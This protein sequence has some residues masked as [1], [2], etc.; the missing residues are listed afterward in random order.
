MPLMLSTGVAGFIRSLSA[1]LAALLVCGG[2]H[3]Q[4]GGA[5]VD[6]K[7]LQWGLGGAARPGGWI[8]VQVQVTDLGQTTREVLLE[9]SIPDPDGDTTLFQ[10]T[11]AV[12]GEKKPTWIYARLPFAAATMNEFV[13]TAHAVVEPSGAQ[14]DAGVARGGELLGRSKFNIPS[15]IEARTG[16]FGVIGRPQVGLGTFKTDAG[17]NSGFAP[18]AHEKVDIVSGLTVSSL[19]DR[20]M[21]LSEMEA[22]VWTGTG[23]DLEP[24]DLPEDRA[25]AIREWVMRGG[26]LIIV[27]PAVGQTWTNPS[28]PLYDIFPRV[29][30]Q[31]LEN[32]DMKP[33]RPLLTDK[34]IDL[35]PDVVQV[36][37]PA[38]DAKPGEATRI[39]TGPDGKAVV[40]SR[41]VGFGAV[42][43]VGLN[44]TGRPLDNA[45]AVKADVFWNRVM[46]RRGRLLTDTEVS[47]AR[48]PNYSGPRNFTNR[49]QRAL[50]QDIP[51]L[52]NKTGQAF[53]GVMLA[54]VL[55]AAY[56]VVAGPLGFWV[57]KRR[58]RTRHAWVGFV[59]VGLCFTALAWG[60][61]TVLKPGKLDAQHL[62][63]VDHVYGQNQ[64]RAKVWMS[65]LLPRFGLM[66]VGIGE[67][68]AA[69]DAKNPIHNTLAP[70]DPAPS[71]LAV[72]ATS[73]FADSQGYGVASRAPAKVLTPARSTTKNYVGEWMGG[74]TWKM[75]MPFTE[76]GSAPG[77]LALAPSNNPRG[78]SIDGTLKHELPGTLKD[79]YVIV[80]RGQKAVRSTEKYIGQLQ[81]EGMWYSRPEWKAGELL[82]VDNEGQTWNHLSAPGRQTDSLLLSSLIGSVSDETDY[83][84]GGWGGGTVRRTGA[85][86]PVSHVPG[87]MP[88]RLM[89]LS[90]FGVLDPP[91]AVSDSRQVL[92]QRADVH[93]Y[94][95]SRWFSRPCVM[96]MGQLENSPSP[97]PLTL[98]GDPMGTTGRTMVRW[99]YPLPD[100]PPRVTG[101]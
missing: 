64:E 52:I 101:N 9:L 25:R 47:K 49:Q 98:N 11:L 35:L 6:L 58:E 60:G 85:Q 37:E 99:V 43:A 40:T 3:A 10:G 18:M 42:T 34:E 93:R 51:G 45:N 20:W 39:L 67:P 89:A 36:L 77:T 26:H 59:A 12:G 63:I 73:S 13:V 80:I 62:T 100:N 54:F 75:P 78:W 29:N 28:Q 17:Y 71:E 83:S 97:V 2:V 84:T 61:A 86:A 57:A 16:I 53:A 88:K 41:T 50:D 24:T 79:V 90:L 69:A 81:A 4:D 70:W 82:D 7:V 92:A 87:S 31:R 22:I 95:L 21:G 32:I 56:W 48:E 91:D 72:S 94:D 44:L 65:V 23:P 1:L 33:Y 15:P 66:E 68:T 5:G 74:P 96:V 46:G 55:F 8:G 27:L 19:P 38:P 30:I 14:R 76:D